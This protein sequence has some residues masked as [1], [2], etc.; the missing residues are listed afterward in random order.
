MNGADEQIAG[1]AVNRIGQDHAR[2]RRPRKNRANEIG[3]VHGDNVKALFTARVEP[4]GDAGIGKACS[5]GDEK[6]NA[7]CPG[8]ELV[9]GIPR[10]ER[11]QNEQSYGDGD[12]NAPAFRHGVG[13]T[14]PSFRAHSVPKTRTPSS[15]S[16]VGAATVVGLMAEPQ[17]V[18]DS[19]TI[20]RSASDR[21]AD[22]AVGTDVHGGAADEAAFDGRA[23]IHRQVAVAFH[24]A[25]HARAGADMK[26]SARDDAAGD[27]LA[28]ANF[29]VAVVESAARRGGEGA[30]P[31][32]TFES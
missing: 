18:P 10:K 21:A 6:N 14:R 28:R 25:E 31:A 7:I 11:G 20:P 29:E 13:T 9:V 4:D 8:T 1:F 26:F 24:A 32:A 12:E 17:C 27:D 15:S 23:G 30:A 3:I 19:I 16:M 5:V 2:A 22:P